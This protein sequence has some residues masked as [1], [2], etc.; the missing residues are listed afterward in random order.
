MIS[1]AALSI[2]LDYERLPPLARQGGP[3]TPAT[4]LGTVLVERLEKTGSFS[5]T[6]GETKQE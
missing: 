6:G 1:E 3:L 4:A 5:F 2:V